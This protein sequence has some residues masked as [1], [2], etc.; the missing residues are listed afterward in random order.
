MSGASLPSQST[1]AHLHH[2]QRP[3]QQ[4]PQVGE[5]VVEV[6]ESAGSVSA[7]EVVVADVQ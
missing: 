1:A 3:K 6:G 7:K 4:V 5:H 2:E